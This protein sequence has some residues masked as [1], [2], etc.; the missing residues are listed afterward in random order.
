LNCAS[1]DAVFLGNICI[2]TPVTGHG[3]PVVRKAFEQVFPLPCL[4]HRE[5]KVSKEEFYAAFEAT[6]VE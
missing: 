5:R 2:S 6:L 3:V 4:P 1:L